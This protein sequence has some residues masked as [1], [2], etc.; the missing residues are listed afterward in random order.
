M[1]DDLRE[2][3][4]RSALFAD[5]CIVGGGAAGISI[6]K[7]LINS[8][9]TIYLVESGG[10]EFEDDTQA[11]YRGCSI[12][13]PMDLDV[14]RYR[15]LGG[16]TSRWTGRCAWLDPIDFASRPWIPASGWPIDLDA[17]IP[18]YPRAER[19]CG[20]NRPWQPESHHGQVPGHIDA[21]LSSKELEQ[22]VWR[23]APQ[24]RGMSL[25]WGVAYRQELR[26]S[27]DMRVLLHA[28]AIAFAADETGRTLKS[29]TVASLTGRHATV[30]A[31]AFV[32]CCGGIENARLLLQSA[33]TV[34]GGLGNAY[35]Q[36]GRYLMQH[37]RGRT[38]EWTPTREQAAVL[39]AMF[40]IFP[41]SDGIQH[42]FGLAL[43]ESAQCRHGLLNCSAILSFDE[44]TSRGWGSF[45][46]A[47][48][49]AR[50]R[51]FTPAAAGFTRAALDPVSVLSNLSRRLG[52]SAPPLMRLQKA[53]LLV[54][55]EQV[56]NADSRVTLSDKRDVLGQRGAIVDWRLT[57]LERRTAKCFTTFAAAA[58]RKAQLG[59]LQPLPWLENASPITVDELSGTYHHIGTTRMSEDPRHGVVDAQCR[60]H[61]THNVY[62]AGCSV[63]ST[64][65]HANPT[66]SIVALA[67]RLADWL[68]S[69]LKQA[70]A[71]LVCADNSSRRADDA[72]QG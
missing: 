36:V 33:E 20:F 26:T 69:T 63:F 15:Q 62:V 67:V 29:I 9:L 47:V 61:G 25:N 56:P 42:E 60:V 30:T 38:A 51:K 24:S 71:D 5:L 58:F 64:G 7:E 43:S 11:L 8:G 50:Q 22:F 1:I 32:L 31:R 68:R 44:D 27:G 23:Y 48:A 54:D 4:D 18:F 59:E 16:S 65:G 28:N 53:A 57:E 40:N 41:E 70:P 12:G 34:P 3:P 19:L 45:K 10:F 72:L 35:G 14:G 17:L 46:A 2:L 39:Q 52:R 49:S 66:L 6:A 21:K 37:P 13:H 55:L